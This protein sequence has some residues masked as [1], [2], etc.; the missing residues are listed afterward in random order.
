MCK[1]VYVCKYGVGRGSVVGRP[2]AHGRPIKL[3]LVP[4][5]APLT[6]HIVCAILSLDKKISSILPSYMTCLSVS[7]C[8][9]SIHRRLSIWHYIYIYP[10]IVQSFD[11]FPPFS[12][13]P[14]ILPSLPPSLFFFRSLFS[15]FNILLVALQSSPT[16]QLLISLISCRVDTRLR[17]WT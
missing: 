5:R 2:Y 14:S 1:Y 8:C 13:S 9:L 12:L 6:K 11:R 16:Y 7:V 3:F 10:L 4:A 17:M 15:L